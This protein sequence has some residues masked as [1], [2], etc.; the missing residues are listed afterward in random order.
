VI[1]QG[2]GIRLELI[3][4]TNIK[5]GITTSAFNAVPDAPISSFELELPQGP[6]SALGANLPAAAH[7][8]FCASKLAMPTTITGQNGAQIK[9]STKIA[10]NGCPK[11]HKAAGKAR[12]TA[13][14]RRLAVG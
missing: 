11:S 7:G 6:H 5:H 1:L 9:Q 8:G 4:N 10:V 13:R 3:G 2:Q 12:R 14:A